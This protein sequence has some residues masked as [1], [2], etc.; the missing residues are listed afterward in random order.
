MPD[1]TLFEP[2][3][4]PIGDRAMQR[5]ESAYEYYRCSQRKSMEALNAHLEE[6][7]ASFPADGKLDLQQRFRSRIKGQHDAAYFE[8]HLHQLF[9]RMEFSLE[10]HPDLEEENSSRL[11]SFARSLATLLSRGHH[12]TRFRSRSQPN[13]AS[14]S[15]PGGS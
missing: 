1:D 12:R 11:P 8:L 7:F 4:E 6:W 2:C 14:E 13:A 10:I 5:T 9:T 15:S 3:P